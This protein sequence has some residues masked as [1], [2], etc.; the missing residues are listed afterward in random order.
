MVGAGYPSRIL[1]II[2]L[3]GS[4]PAVQLIVA[5]GKKSIDAT[6]VCGGD[7]D[8]AYVRG[9]HMRRMSRRQDIRWYTIRRV[10]LRSH[11]EERT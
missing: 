10:M 7:L 11:G 2:P 9:R 4:V 6:T 1:R 5:T 3:L 8:G